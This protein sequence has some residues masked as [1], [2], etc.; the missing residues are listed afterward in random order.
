M[1][2]ILIGAAALALAGPAAAHPVPPGDPRADPRDREIVRAIPNPAEVEAM[3]ETID[4][5]VGAVMDVPVGPLIDAIDAADPEGRRDRRRYRRDERLGDV[6]SGGDPY[7]E[8]RLSD[9][10]RG[11]T[12]GMGVMAEQLAVIAPEMRRAMD[13]AE[14]DIARAMDDARARRE[15]ERAGRR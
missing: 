4:R 7:F 3:G 13:R 11:V 1:R 10:I 14:R 9:Q 8:E 6:A 2:R 5:V 12:A 15:K